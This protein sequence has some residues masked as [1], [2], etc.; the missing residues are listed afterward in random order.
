[1]RMG[2][3]TIEPGSSSQNEVTGQLFPHEMEVVAVG[4]H[5]LAGTLDGIHLGFR[6]EVHRP[7][8]Q[9]PPDIRAALE[10]SR[11]CGLGGRITEDAF[12]EQFRDLDISPPPEGQ[13]TLYVAS[14]ETDEESPRYGRSVDAIT[15]ATQTCMA[16]DR[17]LNRNIEQFR[18][19]V[20]NRY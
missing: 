2:S 10:D 6:V 9:I 3:G 19:A 14:V 4:P 5:V 12:Q 11:S 16:V 17:F 8:Q 1:M 15:G 7:W 13:R 20:A 18:R